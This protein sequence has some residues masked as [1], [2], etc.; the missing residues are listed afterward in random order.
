MTSAP[1][2]IQRAR[3]KG[4]RLPPNTVC[5]SRPSV[6]GNPF[7]WMIFG[8]EVAVDFFERWLDDDLTPSER[9]STGLDITPDA[10]A[11][12]RMAVLSRIPHLRGRNLACWCHLCPRHAAGKPFGEDCRHCDP[13]HADPIGRRANP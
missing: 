8:R 4:W 9:A 5:V 10:V 12:Q 2:R 7:D 11:R 6:L 1:L 3:A 13:C